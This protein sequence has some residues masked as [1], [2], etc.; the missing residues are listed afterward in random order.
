MGAFERFKAA[1][2]QRAVAN[3][4]F[5]AGF[6][7]NGASA[8]TIVNTFD[9]TI[10]ISAAVV[11][12]Q[13]SDIAYIYTDLQNPLEI[14]SIWEV[15]SLH[16]IVAEHIEVIKDVKWYKY[17]CYVCNAQLAPDLW[18]YFKGPEASYIN[19]AL[20]QEAVIQ[21]QQKPILV[22]TANRLTYKD[23]ILINHRPWQITE[24]DDI[25]QPGLVFYSLKPTTISK[26]EEDEAK[27]I[28]KAAEEIP[29]P[30]AAANPHKDDQEKI[31]YVIPETPVKIKLYDTFFDYSGAIQILN[32]DSQYITIALPFGVK[33][34]AITFTSKNGMRNTYQLI[35]NEHFASKEAIVYNE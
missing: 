7:V 11:N 33:D 19:I 17:K 6:L 32:R 18:G 21:S 12:K 5:N 3:R 35:A 22:T 26:I 4:N 2:T 16:L 10:K 15:K 9:K 31:I 30:V 20:K 24:Y 28:F 14:G 34:A 13:E 1:Q 27:T 29:T 25:S 23:K 8:A